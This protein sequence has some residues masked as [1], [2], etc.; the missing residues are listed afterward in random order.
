MQTI[1]QHPVW[2]KLK[3]LQQQLATRSIDE[4][5]DGDAARAEHY[6]VQAADL[7][8]NYSRHRINDEVLRT[9]MTLAEEC[10]LP[11][12]IAQQFAGELI[13][14]TEQRAVLHTALRDPTAQPLWV[15][16]ED[17][18]PVIQRTLAAM[19][20]LVEPV[21]KAGVIT[22]VIN[23]G[24]GGS[25]LGPQLVTEALRDYADG[26]RVHFFSTFDDAAFQQTLSRLDPRRTLVLVVSKTFS[27]AETLHNA[28]IAGAW[29]GEWLAE[30]FIAVTARS[31][32]ALE[33]GVSANNVFPMWDWVG[34]R[35]SLWSAVGLAAAFALGMDHFEALLAGAHAMDQ[36][37]LRAPLAANM[38]V[39]MGLLSI[40]YSN[41]WHAS[42][43]AVLAYS[44]RLCSLPNYLQQS[45]MESLG[46]RVTQQG[47]EVDCATGPIVWG[48]VGTDTQHS[49]HQLLMQSPHCVPIDFVLPL[50]NAPLSS[51]NWSLIAHCLAQAQTLAFGYQPSSDDPLASHKLIPGNIPSS[52][53]LM[54]ALTPHHLGALIALYEHKIFTQSVIWNIN[55]YDQWGVER[56]KQMAGRILADLQADQVTHHYDATTQS[57]LQRI[58]HAASEPQEL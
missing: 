57:L 15:A 47:Y 56:G 58:R 27:T 16:G 38:P 17:I 32:R 45:H 9:L 20:Q 22:D 6:Q 2:Q 43:Q 48:G 4:L 26:P 46:K 31:D 35:F 39:L 29:L 30:H 24:I 54:P 37:F 42:T 23:L 50:R 55:A 25:D 11:S 40:W 19:R 8:L 1:T 12:L 10:Q 41:F 13:N 53:I 52:I 21:R 33:F 3:Q 49:F 28:R 44:P 36:H 18:R 7:T 51:M 34:G 5:V 14:T